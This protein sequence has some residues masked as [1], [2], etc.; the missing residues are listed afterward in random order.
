MDVKYRLTVT[1]DRLIKTAR[2]W[3]AEI[4]CLEGKL[5]EIN[6]TVMRSVGY[7]QGKGG[8]HYRKSMISGREITD[9]LLG[10]IRN[11]PQI[12]LEMAGIYDKSEMDNTK[13]AEGL[14]NR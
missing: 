12:L 7:W 10:K 6:E 9:N 3:S 4:C 1:P 11:S 13:M 14:N 8:D 2:E 5:G